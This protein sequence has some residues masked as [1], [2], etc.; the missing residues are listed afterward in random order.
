MAQ[1]FINIDAS[2][3]SDATDIFVQSLGEEGRCSAQQWARRIWR[4]ERLSDTKTMR[5]EHHFNGE[6]YGGKR[7]SVILWSKMSWNE[8]NWSNL[9]SSA[10]LKQHAR[11]WIG[12]ILTM[13][14][15]DAI[16]NTQTSTTRIDDVDL[17]RVR[18][19]LCDRK[20]KGKSLFAYLWTM[21]LW[22]LHADKFKQRTRVLLRSICSIA[23]IYFRYWM[24]RK[25]LHCKKGSNKK[26]WRFQRLTKYRWR[27]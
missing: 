16:R 7:R 18:C 24:H 25:S 22:A 14:S 17:E 8:L 9:I 1:S 10:L 21:V 11:A 23:R 6:G 2:G 26:H 15:A 3:Q 4:S 27:I 5:P 20:T 12:K 19:H 13:Q